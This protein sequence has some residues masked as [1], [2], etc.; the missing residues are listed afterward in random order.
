MI[1]DRLFWVEKL[2][3]RA[4]LFL[5]FLLIAFFFLFPFFK[6]GNR[7]VILLSSSCYC[8]FKWL[9]IKHNTQKIQL[10]ILGISAMVFWGFFNWSF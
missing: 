1:F 6:L 5:C 2:R 3:H 4:R 9:S 7:M 10:V 8:F